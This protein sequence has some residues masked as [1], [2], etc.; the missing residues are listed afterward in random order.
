LNE[1]SSTHRI[2]KIAIRLA[3][4]SVACSPN[5]ASGERLERLRV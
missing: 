3:T 1:E 4:M 2:G 5:E